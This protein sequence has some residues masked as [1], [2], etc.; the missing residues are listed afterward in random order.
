[1]NDAFFKPSLNVESFIG[2]NSSVDTERFLLF[3]KAYYEWMQSTT[4]SLTNKT[5]TFVVGETIVGAISGAIASIKEVKTNS[6]V[7]APTSRTV[8]AYTESV[9]GQTSGATAT[10]NVIKDN[11][12]RASG[13]ILNYK[14][15]E[16]SVDTYVDYLREELYPSIPATYY[17]NKQLVAQYF[18]DFY[19]SKS[20]EQ[21]YRFLF[22]LLY[23]EDID[24]YY[25]GEDVLRVSDGNFEK[26]QIIRTEAVAVGID[27]TGTPF[28]RDIFLFLNKTIRG[29]TSGVLANVVDIKKFFI[30]SLEVAEMTLKLV[31]GTFAAGEDIVDIDDE[32]L[33]TTI[34]GIVSGVTIVDGGSG[35]E[36]GDVVTITG[37][38]SE[39]QARVSS[40]KESPIS[41]LTVNTIGHGYQLNTNATIDSS[42]TGGSG[43]LV[44]V[45]ALANTYSVTSGANT[46]TVGEISEVSILNRGEGYFKKPAITLQDTTIASLGLLSDKLITINNAGSNYGVGNTLVFTGGSGANA[47]GQIASVVESTT[48]DL[49]FEDGFQMK[50]DG[51]Y[52]DII[53]NEDWSVIGAIKRIELTN[54][55]TGYS[56]ANLP[57]ISITTTTGASA[58]LVATNVQGKS[59]NVTVDTSNNITGIGSIRAVEIT[60][61]GIDYSAANAS[62]ATIGD[63]NAILS[64]VISG[65]GIREGVFLDDDGKIDYKIIQDSY[66]YQD[67]SYVIKSGLTFQTYSNTLKSII[68]PAGLIYFG[69]IQILNDLDVHAELINNPDIQRMLVQ[70]FTHLTVGAEYEYSSI[71]WSIKVEAPVISLNTD[72]LDVQ[73]YVI[74]L[75]PEGDD[76]TGITDVGITINQD[77]VRHSFIIQTPFEL[78]VTATSAT[79]P[80]T[81]FVISHQDILPG[82]GDNIYGNLPMTPFGVYN[83]DWSVVPI[84]VLQ[85]ARFSDLYGE[86]PAYQS[87]MN[88]YID[89]TID[90]SVSGI[91]TKLKYETF[92]VSGTIPLLESI[93]TTGSLIVKP[94]IPIQL[95]LNDVGISMSTV[96]DRELPTFITLADLDTYGEYVVIVSPTPSVLDVSV[97]ASS[98]LPQKFASAQNLVA[99]YDIRLKDIAILNVAGNVFG[100]D[101]PQNAYEGTIGSF[102]NSTFETSY[103]NYPLSYQ[104]YVKILPITTTEMNNLSVN[105]EIVVR[106]EGNGFRFTIYDDL[107]LSDYETS[108]ISA[109]A[110]FTF[111][112]NFGTTIHDVTIK[113][114]TSPYT[115]GQSAKPNPT[116]IFRGE[117][118]VKTQSEP[119][120]YDTLYEDIRISA[121]QTLTFNDV[122]PGTTDIIGQQTFGSVYPQAPQTS[123]TYIKYAKIAGTVS[124]DTQNY[125]L[126]TIDDYSEIPIGDVDEVVFSA[127][128]PVV[129][130]TGTNFETDYD[131][132]DVFVANNEYFTVEA[133]ANTTHMVVD[134]QPINQYSNVF[135]YKVSN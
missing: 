115:S 76:E 97:A 114:T 34:Y 133:I 73:E 91:T 3:M 80:T 107:L 18:K 77:D 121:F 37:D 85:D 47:A 103:L 70:I 99:L 25:P 57:S 36:D 46:F 87:I 131:V 68:H 72:L 102:A 2:E 92:A 108:P 127:S 79:L 42:G 125:S 65:L 39:A 98:I 31:S 6:I 26:T 10:I 45:T 106:S 27:A 82:Y 130:G 120:A 30:G 1:M 17:G 88:L 84:S 124:S 60:N 53:K 111:D 21:S 134:R 38:G 104:E 61:F 15:L 93:V 52:Y 113:A 63:G 43:F 122:V 117:I 101:L 51:S 105:R 33:V 126:F 132:Y 116:D 119:S 16:T 89:N 78:N 11:V 12:G 44:Q 14:N 95:S 109:L 35:Y 29:K 96:M 123:A 50:A 56:S 7:I 41:A 59:A 5:G 118:L 48:F 128:A 64:P 58:N 8:F 67:Y 22:K 54:F 19:E 94:E 135:A 55:G 9:T 69:E 23:N 24:F 110:D 49:L 66:Y 71:T 83:E 32:D 86:N 129:V 90:L 62:A 40:I 81:K 28:S 20:N 74:H 112:T 4:L 13:N 100:D 75:V